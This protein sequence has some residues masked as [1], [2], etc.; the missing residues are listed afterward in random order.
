M[1]EKLHLPFP[2]L[3]DVVGDVMK[4][5]R[6]SWQLPQELQEKYVSVRNRNFDLINL[7]AGW[8]LPV[9]AT[10]IIDREATIRH[11]QINIDYTQRMEPEEIVRILATL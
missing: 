11:V 6:I 3:T 5:Y 4:S 8:S 9:P 2:V 1:S 7:G 10:Y